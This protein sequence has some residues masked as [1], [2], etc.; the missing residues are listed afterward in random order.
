METATAS[1]LAHAD[2]GSSLPL[3]PSDYFAEVEQDADEM[4]RRSPTLSARLGKLVLVL[5]S[6][7]VT[8]GWTKARGTITRTK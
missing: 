8:W 1:T 4:L 3:S 5:G 2:V 7:A 6:R